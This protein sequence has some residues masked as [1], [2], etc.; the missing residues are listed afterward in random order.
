MEVSETK[1]KYKNY[2]IAAILMLVFI[3]NDLIFDY[4]FNFGTSDFISFLFT[5]GASIIVFIWNRKLKKSRITGEFENI[6][7]FI[8]SNFD[9]WQLIFSVLDIICGI[10]SLLSGLSLL[11]CIFKAL[12]VFYIPVKMIVVTNKEKSLITAVSKAS[13]VWV[14]GRTITKN[15]KGENKMKKIITNIKNNP[16]TI[17]FGFIAAFVFGVAAYSLVMTLW[18]AVWTWLLWTIVGVSSVIAFLGCCWIGWDKAGQFVLRTADKVLDDT[19]YNQLLELCD[20]LTVEQAAANKVKS[21]DKVKAKEK[22]KADKV[23]AKQNKID[24]KEAKALAK[25]QEKQEAK[26]AELKAKADREAHIQK[27]A[28]EFR[29]NKTE[30]SSN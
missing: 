25:R 22:A 26:E 15:K 29:N 19:R 28:E 12:K 11:A 17:I 6:S 24:R 4:L 27:L 23:A 16:K 13:I 1:K 3:F 5:L 9:N 2:Y 30:N 21:E 8:K 10:I 20:K 14:I 18:T 7:K